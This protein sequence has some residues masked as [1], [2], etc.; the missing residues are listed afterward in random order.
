MFMR[1]IYDEGLAHASYLIGCQRTGEAIVIDPARDVDRY[2]KMALDEKLRVVAVAETHI[3]ADFV[4]GARELAETA[5]AHVYVSDEGP[6]EWKTRWLNASSAPHTLLRDGDTFS[7]GKIEF[8][9]VHTPGHTPEHICFAVTDRGGGATEPMGVLT[10]DFV[11]VGDL[12]RPDLL[13]TAAGQAGAMEPAAHELFSSLRRLDELP[14]HTQVWPGHGAGSA[15]G[16]DLGAVLTST[17]GYERRFNR[18]LAEARDEA[19]FVRTI[20]E[21]Q[22]E[23]PLYFA[24]MKQINRDGPA[25]LNGLPTPPKM[26]AASFRDLNPTKTVFADIRPWDEF[27]RGHIPGSLSFPLVRSFSTD[28]GSMLG[29]DDDICLIVYPNDLEAALRGLVRVG[30]ENVRGWLDAGELHDFSDPAHP[31]ATLDEVDVAGAGAVTQLVE[32]QLCKL[33]V[34][35]S[36]LLRSIPATA[37]P[38]RLPCWMVCTRRAIL[39]ARGARPRTIPGAV[40][41]RLKGTDC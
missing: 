9:A 22:P 17:I 41:E 34:G 10:G 23:P 36:S 4:S 26:A 18:T 33:E 39:S 31:L 3:H 6:D 16:K 1:T 11:F 37:S 27:R 8:R 19:A 14:D 28:T 20:L 24:R 7:I 32:C 25:V 29:P 21:G 30:L 15:C 38:A 2:I 35:S 5:G 12:G 13:E 40:P